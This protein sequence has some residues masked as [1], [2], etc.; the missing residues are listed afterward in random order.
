E[1]RT[2]AHVTNIDGDGVSIGAERIEAR[3]VLWAAGVAA[4][5]LARSLGVPLDK[6]GRVVVEPDLTIPGR[7][8]VSVIGRLAHCEPDGLRVRGGG[9]SPG[10]HGRPPAPDH[11][12]A[13]G[14]H[15]SRAVPLRGQGNACHDRPLQSV[16]PPR[17]DQGLRTL[18]L[19]ALAVRPYPF[20]NGFPQP[21]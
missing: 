13:S 20:L 10:A 9:Q 7:D 5:P 19:A 15:P 18:S 12:A 21:P 16:R 6:A 4:S 14:R 3:T 2:G 11:A 17:P 1:V 8:D